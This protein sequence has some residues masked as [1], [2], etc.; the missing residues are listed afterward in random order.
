MR[1][2]CAP[3]AFPQSG[4]KWKQTGFC[5]K[6]CKGLLKALASREFTTSSKK[7]FA[8]H[9]FICLDTKI[10][11]FKIN[12]FFLLKDEVVFSE[13][14]LN[15]IVVTIK[16]QSQLR[17]SNKIGPWSTSQV[18]HT[19]IGW[20]FGNLLLWRIASVVEFSMR[21]DNPEDSLSLSYL[22]IPNTISGGVGCSPRKFPHHPPI[23]L[24]SCS[25]TLLRRLLSSLTPSSRK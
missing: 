16:C 1:F 5:W 15:S 18:V 11:L 4:K 17:I 19:S 7:I 2:Q 23:F 22:L 9:I 12:S 8:Y 24:L 6:L 21:V 13:E 25:S 10:S 14:V 3:F 20:W